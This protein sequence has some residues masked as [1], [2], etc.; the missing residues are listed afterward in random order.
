VSFLYAA[1]GSNLCDEDEIHKVI[2]AVAMIIHILH[3]ILTMTACLFAFRLALFGDD[4]KCVGKEGRIVGVK[5]PTG[6]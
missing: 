4:C 3:T 5:I 2:L 6:Y 1:C